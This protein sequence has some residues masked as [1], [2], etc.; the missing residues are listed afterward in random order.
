MLIPRISSSPRTPTSE[1]W[2]SSRSWRKEDGEDRAWSWN[3]FTPVV[4]GQGWEA[5]ARLV[6]SQID[7]WPQRKQIA[8]DIIN[9]TQ[10]NTK[11]IPIKYRITSDLSYN[12][13]DKQGSMRKNCWNVK[14]L[15]LSPIHDPLTMAKL[16]VDSAGIGG[17][18][19]TRE[20]MT[21]STMPALGHCPGL[22]LLILKQIRSLRTWYDWK[23]W[24]SSKTQT[25][26]IY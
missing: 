12:K 15:P 23:R 10:W 22:L 4:S 19:A 7:C 13:E 6:N 24:T 16:L 3:P 20:E 5:G 18:G 1:T 9:C 11:A 21:T 17:R 2:S 25:Y 26:S 14:V 8:L